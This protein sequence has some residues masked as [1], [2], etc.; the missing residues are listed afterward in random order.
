M[1]VAIP[2]SSGVGLVRPH[3]TEVQHRPRV[4]C[5][6][7]VEEESHKHQVRALSTKKKEEDVE[8]NSIFPF[9]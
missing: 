9:Y 3:F 1:T 7:P 5:V 2:G 8:A 4:E 6:E